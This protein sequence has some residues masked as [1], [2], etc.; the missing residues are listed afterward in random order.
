MTNCF[1]RRKVRKLAGRKRGRKCRFCTLGDARRV[2]VL[3]DAEDSGA[4]EPCL[5]KLRAAHKKVSVCMYIA[6]DKPTKTDGM[7]VCAKTDLDMWYMPRKTVESK[8]YAC[9]AD[10]LIDLTREGN[11]VMQYLLLKHPAPFKV[12]AKSRESDLYDLTVAVT[13][14]A[15]MR[16]VFEQIVFYLQTIRFK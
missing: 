4:V 14:N 1:L 8:F 15:D 11:Y 5:K 6:D 16:Y 2:L 3:F 7:T 9:D 12:G 10:I 13:E